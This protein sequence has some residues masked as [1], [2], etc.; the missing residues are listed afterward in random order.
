M[1]KEG[2][3]EASI[4]P[5]LLIRHLSPPYDSKQVHIINEHE[6]SSQAKI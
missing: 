4:V 1:S 2:T 5:H 3:I 6:D